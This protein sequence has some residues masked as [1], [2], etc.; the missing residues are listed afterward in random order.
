[1]SAPG[2]HGARVDG[3]AACH[4]WRR[5]TGERPRRQRSG[6]GPAEGVR[7][8]HPCRHPARCGTPASR[9]GPV[10]ACSRCSGSTRRTASTARAA[11]GPSREHRAPRR[12]LRERRQGGRRGGDRAPG[13][14]REFFAE[15]TR[16]RAAPRSP[17]TGSASRAGS[18]SRWC[19][20][21]GG[22]HYEPIALG[23]RV[24]ADRR[25]SCSA[26]DSPGRGRLLHLGPHQ[27]RGGV[28]LPALRPRVRH[29]QPARLLEHVPRVERRRADRDASA[30]ARARSRSTTSTQ[31]DADPRRRPE[32]GHQPPAHADR[33]AR[34]PSAA[35]R[36]IVAI[37][38]LPEAGPAS[39]SRTRS[40]RSA[41]SAGARAL[42]DLFLPDPHRRRP[43][44]VPG[45]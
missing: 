43:G 29:Q 40:G 1:M 42:A 44:A 23:R 7:G 38:P 13:R 12:V 19:C 28:P 15:H 32:P 9:W 24:R 36:R 8:R 10:A 14:R 26:L 4:R 37:N 33:A 34:R 27:Q 20:A 5:A 18:P 22:D 39:A 25:A 6:R 31:A 30:S 45:V 11:P 35:G 41:C 2:H 17:T 3:N 21:P 16:R